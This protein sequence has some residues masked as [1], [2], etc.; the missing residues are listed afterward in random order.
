M[1]IIFLLRNNDLGARVG[2]Q[3]TQAQ[4][5]STY[6]RLSNFQNGRHYK[7]FVWEFR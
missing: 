2:A 4:Y 3:A 7:E 1:L 5:E 6:V